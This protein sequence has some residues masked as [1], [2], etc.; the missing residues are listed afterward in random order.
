MTR[1]D[2]KMPITL[3]PKA[4]FRVVL[5]TDLEKSPQPAFLYRHLS[6]IEAKRTRESIASQPDSWQQVRTAILAG[7][8]GWEYLTD[9]ASGQPIA[10]DA[11]K[12]DLI[13][14]V[15]TDIEIGELLAKTSHER[16]MT[17]E[18]RKKSGPPLPSDAAKSAGAV[19]GS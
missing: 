12:P 1:K 17:A 13:L 14:E 2:K 5:E 15:C 11:A 18:D 9:P 16:S 8:V 6:A 7:L 3:D 4:V 19:A 10:F